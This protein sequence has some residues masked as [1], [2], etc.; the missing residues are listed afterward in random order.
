[1]RVRRIALFSSFFAAFAACTGDDLTGNANGGGSVDGGSE[2]GGVLAEGG[3][4]TSAVTLTV[5][6]PPS[7]VQGKSIG[8]DLTLARAG[9]IETLTLTA[10][11]L[12][13]GVST[14]PVTVLPDAAKAVLTLTATPAAAHGTRDV[15]ITAQN[16]AGEVRADVRVSVL[17][18]GAS[19]TLDTTFAEGG[20]APIVPDLTFVTDLRL[21]NGGKAYVTGRKQG[22]F[23]AA[24]ILF[25]GKTDTTFGTAGSVVTD[26]GGENDSAIASTIDA[27]GKLVLMGTAGNPIQ[28]GAARYDAGGVLDANF[29]KPLATPAGATSAG[30]TCGILD[31]KNRILLGGH[32]VDGTTKMAITRLTATGGLDTTFNT[33][34]S[35][36]FTASARALAIAS[37][38]DGRLLVGGATATDAIIA[39][40]T[41]AGAPD[42]TFGAG[43][44]KTTFIYGTKNENVLGLVG[45][46]DGTVLVSGQLND[47]GG[48][49]AT[50]Y[51]ALFDATGADFVGSF[52]AGAS[53]GRTILDLT[54]GEPTSLDQGI[55]VD[56]AGGLWLTGAV[57]SSSIFVVKLRSNGTF[58][59]DFANG[60]KL[61]IP[62]GGVYSAARIALADDGRMWL[63]ASKA[64]GGYQLFRYWI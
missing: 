55:V 43:G 10:T 25:D 2:D 29:G 30:A 41:E 3:S 14:A 31:A 62:T 35:V 26:F 24:R 51:V 64:G 37:Y 59:T 54:P 44:V 17:V 49:P 23:F 53:P 4:S 1:M 58:D 12:G 34:G 21:A 32:V 18:R 57:G 42:S 19:G 45:R 28:L 39:R 15:R 60:G 22:D 61:V 5:G 20:K 52:G 47:T 7:L 9:S 36:F 27:A 50:A 38:P 48:A 46:A 40:L 13:E 6:A 56:G 63:V 33:T 11:E 8:L 16:P